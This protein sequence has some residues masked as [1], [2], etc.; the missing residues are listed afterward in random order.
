MSRCEDLTDRRYGR[1]LVIERAENKGGKVSWLCR[2]DCG[3]EVSVRA[4]NLK[5][6]TSSC[7]CLNKEASR[8]ANSTHGESRTKL[9]R[10][11][12]SMRDRCRPTSHVYEYY[13]GRGITVCAEWEHDYVAFRDWALANGY[14]PGLTID[15]IDNDSG[16]SPDNCRWATWLEQS[17]NK[18]PK[19]KRVVK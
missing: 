6:G 13:R 8:A 4:V 19:R 15:R 9:Y 10:V 5:N 7:G 14:K 17:K 1:L 2:C 16:Y 11:W 18:R 3:N 12:C